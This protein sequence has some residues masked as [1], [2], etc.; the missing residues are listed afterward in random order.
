LRFPIEWIAVIA[1]VSV[2]APL[3]GGIANNLSH[4][5]SNIARVLA[6]EHRG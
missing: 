6:G 5:G 2:A 3:L 4:P 1:T